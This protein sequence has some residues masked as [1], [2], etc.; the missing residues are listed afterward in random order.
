[1]NPTLHDEV[2]DKLDLDWSPGRSPDGCTGSMG[3]IRDD[4]QPE[5]IYQ[6]I[7]VN[8]AGGCAGH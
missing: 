1:M 8:S 3:R 2:Q 6:C 4:D 7:Y 5:A